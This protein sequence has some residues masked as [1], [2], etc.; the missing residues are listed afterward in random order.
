MD[1]YQKMCDI[2]KNVTK[3]VMI[4]KEVYYMSLQRN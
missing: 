1:A 2:N 4:I 3:I